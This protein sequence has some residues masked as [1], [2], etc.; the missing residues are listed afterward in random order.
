MRYEQ[1][2]DLRKVSETSYITNGCNILLFLYEKLIIHSLHP[3]LYVAM[4]ICGA[5]LT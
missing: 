5:F 3:I 2:L 4:V 1:R